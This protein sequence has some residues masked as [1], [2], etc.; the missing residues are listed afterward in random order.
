MVYKLKYVI[1]S[2]RKRYPN[3]LDAK[4]IIYIYVQAESDA[5]SSQ[6]QSDTEEVGPNSIGPTIEDQMEIVKH[7][8]E[9]KIEEQTT[10]D[11][12]GNDIMLPRANLI[13]TKER[14]ESKEKSK[15]ELEEEEREKMQCVFDMYYK[16]FI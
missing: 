3:L 16:E 15:K 6:S 10:E 8:I 9:T 1:N 2:V 13:S 11:I 7:E 14:R 5:M 12:F 4:S